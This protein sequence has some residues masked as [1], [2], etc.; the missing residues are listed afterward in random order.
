MLHNND[1]NMVTWEERVLAGDPKNADSQNLPDFSYSQ[2]AES[3]GLRGIRLD[4]PD[5]IG[6]TW[7]VALHDTRPVVIDAITDPDV[8]P[9]PPHIT[10]EQ[11]KADAS[12]LWKG[13]PNRTGI[14]RQTF[15]DMI[16]T[17]L[18]HRN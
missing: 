2:Y 9:L 16:E 11:A 15:R 13:D 12:A 3:L 1:L 18:P 17:F 8:P 5:N 7:D 14:V 4:S 10:L 6:Q